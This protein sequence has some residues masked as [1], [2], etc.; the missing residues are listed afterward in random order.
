MRSAEDIKRLVNNAQVRIDPE[1][2]GA[3]LTEL[4]SKLE[5]AVENQPDI[6]S[7]IMHSNKVKFS[8]ALL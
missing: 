4:V 3:G 6:R 7:K 8:I 2:K 5:S 1:K